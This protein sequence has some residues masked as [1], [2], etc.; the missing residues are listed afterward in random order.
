MKVIFQ[1][2]D[3]ARPQ[4]RLRSAKPEIRDHGCPRQ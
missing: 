3:E 4:E 1:L 2:L